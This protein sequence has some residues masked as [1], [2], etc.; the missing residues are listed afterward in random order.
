MPRMIKPDVEVALPKPSGISSPGAVLFILGFI[1]LFNYVDRAVVAPLVPLLQK[2]VSQGGLGLSGSQAGSLQLAFMIVHS[3]ASVPL[4]VAADRYLR[5]RVIASGVALWSLATALGGLAHSFSTLFL[6]RAAVGI[7]EATYA[8]AASALISERFSPAVR[9][10]AL[11]AFQLGM[12][13]GGAIGVA[14]GGWVGGRWGFRI[15]FFVVGLP[16]LLLAGLTLF[17]YEAR[18]ERGAVSSPMSSAS[19]ALPAR[20]LFRSPAI[21]W[22]H[23]TGV[24]V[25]FFTGAF[26]FWGTAFILRYHYGGQTERYLARVSASFGAAATLGGFLGVLAG[27]FVA[28]RL[29][30]RHQGAGR[31]MAIAI[32]ALA[33]IPC[34]L[35]GLYASSLW[36]LYVAMTLGIFFIVWYVGPILAVLHDVAPSRYR[37]TATGIYLTVVHLLGDA[38]SPWIVG[39]IAD[40]TGSLRTGLVCSVVALLLCGLAALMAIPSARKVAELKR[41]AAAR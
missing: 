4:G 9:A 1:N 33:S 39:K 34:A 6:A 30:E 27:S 14:L 2:P 8:P 15:A 40:R 26:I 28:D 20:V 16:G 7:G 12:V 3:L 18:R 24:F 10:R 23:V 21:V 41:R 22:I 5:T 19:L 17:V 25:T 36:L 31:L 35:L 38:I 37:A 11:G 13:L 29:E 32:G